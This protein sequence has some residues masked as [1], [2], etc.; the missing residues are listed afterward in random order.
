[1]EKRLYRSRTDRMIFGVCG[2]LA[3]YVGMDPSIVRILTVLLALASAGFAILAYLAMAVIVPVEGS[4]NVEPRDVV[5][6]NAEDIK[7]TAQELGRKIEDTFA[8]R[9]LN[10]QEE[11]ALQAR[12]RN[13]LGVVIIVIGVVVLLA[14]LNAF[15]WWAFA[16]PVALI[17]IG[18][19]ILLS[20]TRR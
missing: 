13:V 12:R 1:M 7:N 14:T 16:F 8:S 4:Q 15:R 2:G 11:R 10:E 19:V 18:V 20:V 6:E 5:A 3:R 17:I 9:G